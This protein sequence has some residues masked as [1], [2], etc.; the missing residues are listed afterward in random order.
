MSWDR[1]YG[2]VQRRHHV[3][4]LQIPI[5]GQETSS[6]QYR[7]VDEQ[8]FR[9]M[10]TLFD[11]EDRHFAIRFHGGPKAPLFCKDTN[12]CAGSNA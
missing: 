2:K 12:R 11:Q 7:T 3:Q 9:A 1:D 10:Q 5:M 4:P 8:M 6:V